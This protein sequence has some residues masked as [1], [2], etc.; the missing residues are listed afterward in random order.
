[1][2]NALVAPPAGGVSPSQDSPERSGVPATRRF[3]VR[4]LAD[5]YMA[6]Y[7]GRDPARCA[8]FELWCERIGDR[9]AV[10]VDADCVADEV[11]HFRQ[12]P[13][14]RYI[15]RDKASGAR[16]Y[17]EVGP[18]SPA[19][20]N[21]LKSALSALFTWAKDRRRRLLPSTWPNPCRDIP[22][23]K[24]GK[25]RTRFLS[26]DER[27]RL[28]KATR[29][30]AYPRLYC[31]VLIALITGARR[32]ELLALR[33]RD[34]DLH[35]KTAHVARSKNGEQRVLPLTDQVLAELARLRAPHP[36]AFVFCSRFD[37]ARQAAIKKAWRTAVELA[38]I[39]DFRFHD[40]RHSCASYLAQSGASLLEIADVLGHRQL[41]VTRR[42]SH[43]T[44]DNKRTLVDRV[45]GQLG[46][47][48]K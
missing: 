41:D 16:C 15:G 4:E 27:E 35:A 34:V 21:R 18:R 25:G 36:D 37:P 8:Y 13:A 26:Q 44:V 14:R 9:V 38:S 48:A 1:M 45:L 42:Y 47:Y 7:R 30:S 12:R 17:R 40:L 2:T 10:D 32:G 33:W 43:L 29:V 46:G 23:E 39:E 24:E 20:L 3:T 19:S 5:A 22:N 28:L 11:E 31:L 6:G